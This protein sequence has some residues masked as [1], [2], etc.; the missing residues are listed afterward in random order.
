L[1]PTPSPKDQVSVF[2]Y[3][4]DRVAHLY[5]QAPDSLFVAFKVSQG[6]GGR[7]QTRLHTG[8]FGH[9]I[10]PNFWYGNISLY[11]NTTCVI[12][13]I[14]VPNG[15]ITLTRK[16]GKAVLYLPYV[17]YLYRL[18]NKTMFQSL[19]SYLRSSILSVLSERINIFYSLCNFVIIY[20]LRCLRQTKS[21]CCIFVVPRK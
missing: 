18:Q 20:H 12:N 19:C 14:N 13:K 17:M 15:I 6:Y 8:I 11:S 5:P 4:N 9:S 10:F 2:M 3:P 7:I 16:D 21:L 1:L